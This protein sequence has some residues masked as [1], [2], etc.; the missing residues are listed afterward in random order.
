[1]HH[2]EVDRRRYDLPRRASGAEHRVVIC[3]TPRS[4]SYLLCRQMINAGIGVPHEYFRT[5]TVVRLAERFGVGADDQLAYADALEASRTTGNGVFAAK[6]Q[7]T[8]LM[9]Y[10]AVRERILERADV[11]IHLYRRDLVAQAVSWQVSL[12]TGYWS[13][14]ATAGPRDANIDLERTD[15]TLVLVRELLGQNRQWEALLAGIG[16][17]VLQVPY[18]SYVSDQPALL[19]RVAAALA[20]PPDAWRVPPAEARDAHLPVHVEAARS[21]LLASARA[22]TAI[23]SV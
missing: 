4:G 11:L 1:M 15:Q 5:R 16:R 13:F 21:R 12:A 22:A 9:Q 18:E 14:D 20:L 23:A 6:V 2:D 7:W 17:P 8:Q 19:H 10:P 3:S